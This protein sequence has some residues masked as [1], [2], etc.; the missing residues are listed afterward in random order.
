MQKTLYSPPRQGDCILHPRGVQNVAP[1]DQSSGVI[2]FRQ[3]RLHQAETKPPAPSRIMPQF[4]DVSDVQLQLRRLELQ[5]ER[6][7]E[8]RQQQYEL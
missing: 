4:S 5:H 6:E 3:D 7:R 8:E 2:R 1:A